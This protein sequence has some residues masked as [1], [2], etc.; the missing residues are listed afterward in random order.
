[1]FLFVKARLRRFGVGISLLMATGWESGPIMGAYKPSKEILK[2]IEFEYAPQM[3]RLDMLER[4][5]N[6]GVCS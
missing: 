2:K 1:M 5:A 4:F 6:E 3:Q